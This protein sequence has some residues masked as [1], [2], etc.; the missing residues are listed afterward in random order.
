MAE[1]HPWRERS[2][3][4]NRSKINNTNEGEGN[5][6]KFDMA[7]QQTDVEEFIHVLS[8][9]RNLS[10]NTIKA[11]YGDLSALIKWL[12]R[13]EK[14]ALDSGTIAGYFFYLQGER[15]MAARSIRRKYVTIQQYCSYLNWKYSM[16]ERFFNFSARRFQ[17]PRTLPR[18]LTSEEIRRLIL[19]VDE[20]YEETPSEYIRKLCVRNMCIIELLFCLGLRIGEVSAMNLEDYRREEHAV[21]I[22][23]KGNKERILYISSPAVVKKMEAWLRLREEESVDSPAV[24]ISRR[25]NRLSIYSIE[26]VF[27]KYRNRA[28]INPSATPHFLRHS[29]ATQLLNNGASIRDV[30][31]LLGH[32]SLMTTQIYTE[33]SMS[34]KMEVMMKYNGRNRME[35]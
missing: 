24:F 26:N 35:V 9:E 17:M 1:R 14:S 3:S 25:G 12:E 33:V 23:G 29:F 19:S 13:E 15:R 20:E 4:I 11:Y 8:L 31:E 22:H 27:Y 30:Q 18:T 5:N 21:L 6:M 28:R 34:R 32:S 10:K 2:N 7:Q 16:G